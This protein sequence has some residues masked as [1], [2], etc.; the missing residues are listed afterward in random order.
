MGKKKQRKSTTSALKKA[1]RLCQEANQYRLSAQWQ[2]AEQCYR[3]ALSHNPDLATAHDQLGVVLAEVGRLGDALCSIERS[4][5]IDP[6]SHSA[7]ANRGVV[8]GMLG[9]MGAAVESF[10]QALRIEPSNADTRMNLALKLV[11]EGCFDRAVEEFQQVVRLDPGRVHAYFHLAHMKNRMTSDRE[12]KAMLRLY[13][14][15]DITDE[16]KGLL[17]FGLGS[18]LDKRGEYDEAFRY[19]SA[20]HR[21]KRRGAPFNL[22]G[23][24]QYFNSMKE[25]FNAHDALK[26]SGGGAEDGTPI[27]IFGMPRSG[28]TLTE[29]ILASHPDIEGGG[30]L[31]YVEELVRYTQNR[32]GKSILECWKDLDAQMIRELSAIYLDKLRTHSSE[33]RY[34]TDTT[35]MNFL[36]LGLVATILP[37]ARLVHCVRDPM[38][39][40]LSIYQQP[41]S[42]AHAYAHDLEDLGGFYLLYKDL[43][44]HWHNV[45]PGR[46]YNVHYEQLVTE[47]ENEI[48]KLLAFCDLNFHEACLAF[49]TTKRP[50]KTPSATQVRQPVYTASVGRWKRYETGLSRLREILERNGKSA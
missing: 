11:D 12:I 13:A 4:L 43:M 42:D 10:R 21:L 5:E 27:F 50:V 40:C 24:A 41:L 37:N 31:S 9:Q 18:A 6:A 49:H 2:K 39:T 28:T 26:N 20:G 35:P 25:V 33:A 45:L 14:R 32:T 22:A 1:R 15:S 29:Q 3:Q 46:I 44:A 7:H 36:Y 16:D 30:E 34:I 38:D 17:A 8:L 23:Y 48:H 47:T 19:F